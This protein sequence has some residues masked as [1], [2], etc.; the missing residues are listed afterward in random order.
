MKQERTS[1]ELIIVEQLPVIKE[2]LQTIKEQIRARTKEALAL[3]C[4]EE[5]VKEIK[6]VRAELTAGFKELEAQRKTVKGK[7]L[8]P[9]E[10]FESV[11]KACVTD[12]YAPADAELKSRIDEAESIVKAQKHR[13]VTGHFDECAKA[14]GIDFVRFEQTGIAVGLSSSTKNLK[15]DAEK[16][17]DRV[18]EELALIDTQEHKEEI[19]VEYKTSL[20]AVAAITAV[21]RR[22]EA[23]EAERRRAEEARAVKEQRETERREA[24]ARKAEEAAAVKK[25]REE[26]GAIAA[27]AAPSDASEA[28]APPEA[29]S[30]GVAEI[31]QEEKT[32][33]VTLTVCGTEKDI[34]ALEAFL[35]ERGC[36]YE[37][38]PF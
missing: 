21:T 27:S 8:A 23:V 3:D 35:D 15:A 37:Y 12:I 11:Y 10:Q 29:K 31:A 2:R 34:K 38:E 20:D 14:K 30:A 6:K 26:A 32:L 5:T 7:V 25:A 9:Y 28:A 4:T 1:Q 16:F 33:N 18:T 36:E 17:I 19:L 13:E 24:E 22:H